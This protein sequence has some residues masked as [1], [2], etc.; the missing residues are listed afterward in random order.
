MPRQ[1]DIETS[2]ILEFIDIIRPSLSATHCQTGR[3]YPYRS[4]R[5]AGARDVRKR[6]FAILGSSGRVNP[7]ALGLG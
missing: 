4:S 5:K 6:V 7:G 2:E 3:T 1:N